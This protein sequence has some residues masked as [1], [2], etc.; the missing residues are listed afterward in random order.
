LTLTVA[1]LA[2]LAIGLEAEIDP[3]LREG[4]RPRYNVAP[5]Q[6]H[7]ILRVVEAGRRLLVPAEWGLVTRVA[8]E[9]LINARAETVRSRA[10]FRD[11]FAARRCVVPADGFYEWRGARGE[12]EPVWFHAPDGAPLW[13]AGLYD[14]PVAAGAG[15]PAE[16]R[17]RFTIVTTA[18]RGA[19]AEVH[20]RMP[21]ILARGA[22]ARWLRGPAPDGLLRASEVP[23][24]ARAASRRVNSPDNDDA[25]CLEP[26]VDEA[27]R[28]LRLF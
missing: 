17:T 10:A 13:L 4:W 15:A 2:E 25:R 14:E 20:D 5:S 23:L 19:V 6:P 27:P 28:Q 16:P 22:L 8:G 21:L 12:R 9:R 18:A 24:A 7:P 1:S 26:D 3:A 11:A